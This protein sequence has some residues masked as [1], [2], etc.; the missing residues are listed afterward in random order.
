MPGGTGSVAPR[1]SYFI[2]PGSRFGGMLRERDC[3]SCAFRCIEVGDFA[4]WHLADI[5]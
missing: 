2:S 4:Y 5:W 3:A 1:F